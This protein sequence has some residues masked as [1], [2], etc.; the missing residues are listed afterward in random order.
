MATFW[1]GM[2]VCKTVRMVCICEL[3]KCSM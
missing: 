2:P 3:L 1:E